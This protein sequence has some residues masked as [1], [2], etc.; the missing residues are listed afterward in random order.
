MV[1]SL[2]MDTVS[3]TSLPARTPS[4]SIFHQR[5][6][7]LKP[8]PHVSR[9]ALRLRCGTCGSC[10]WEKSEINEQHPQRYSASLCVTSSFF[11]HSIGNDTQSMTSHFHVIGL[12]FPFHSLPASLLKFVFLLLSDHNNLLIT[13]QCKPLSTDT[14]L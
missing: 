7:V 3:V 14:F 12:C 9:K 6:A 1:L 5:E 4:F 13:D 11:L 10:F 2:M 8:I